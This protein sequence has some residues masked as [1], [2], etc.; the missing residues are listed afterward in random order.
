MKA[1]SYVFVVG[2]V[3]ALDKLQVNS[4]HID[5]PLYWRGARTR[6]IGRLR[7]PSIIRPS[8]LTAARATLCVSKGD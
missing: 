2:I 4:I 6:Q 5:L 3:L 1:E 8:I 7:A